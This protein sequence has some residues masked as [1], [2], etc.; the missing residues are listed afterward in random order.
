[1]EMEGAKNVSMQ[2]LIGKEEGSNNIIMRKF[3][4]GVGGHTPHHTHDF[5]HVVKIV[6]GNGYLLDSA[7]KKNS[8]QPGQSAFVAP[9]EL[10]Q[11]QNASSNEPFEFLCIILN[12]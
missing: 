6:S 9:G 2:I 5:E 4:L 8:L 3:T 7:G 10:H 12:S 1:M 11:F